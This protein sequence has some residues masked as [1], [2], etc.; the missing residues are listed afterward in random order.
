[1]DDKILTSWNGL[2]LGAIARASAVL[3]D[4]SYLAAAEKNLS[5]LKK[6]MWDSEKKRLY[7]RWRDGARDDAQIFDTHAYLLSGIVELYGVTLNT[8]Y[9]GFAIEVADRM[10]DAFYDDKAGGFYQSTG[11]KDLIIR[12]KEDY[13]GA[14]PSGNSVGVLAL[15]KLAAITGKE[16]YREVADKTLSYFS[17][18]MKSMALA[19]PYM[20]RAADFASKEPNRVVIAG[21]ANSPKAKELIRAVH[22]VY[23]PHKVI[24]GTDGP[25]EEFAKSLADGDKGNIEAFLCKGKHCELPTADPT[26]LQGLLLKKEK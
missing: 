17:G 23:Q 22:S 25:I 21:S 9:L 24:L 14:E 5:F 8:E 12:L 19:V 13:D 15:L 6:N 4:D 7:H 10:I 1:M 2:M 11:T 3:G 26:K 16:S 20:V 18:R